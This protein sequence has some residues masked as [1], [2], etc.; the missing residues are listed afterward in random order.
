MRSPILFPKAAPILIAGAA[1]QGP[2]VALEPIP[3]RADVLADTDKLL[4]IYNRIEWGVAGQEFVAGSLQGEEAELLARMLEYGRKALASYVPATTAA[5]ALLDDA[6]ATAYFC[7]TYQT[8]ER[9]VAKVWEKQ[10]DEPLKL[11]IGRQVLYTYDDATS[12]LGMV[13]DTYDRGDIRLDLNG[14][15]NVDRC[16]LVK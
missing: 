7:A 4:S 6:M 1:Q 2:A 12:E 13:L 3:G 15:V 5:Q 11:L 14:V 9:E 10:V 8:A 16:E